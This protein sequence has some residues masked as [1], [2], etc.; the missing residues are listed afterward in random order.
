MLLPF[1][2]TFIYLMASLHSRLHSF[3]HHFRLS[4]YPMA[5]HVQPTSSLRHGPPTVQSWFARNC[6]WQ[7]LCSNLPMCKDIRRYK[8]CFFLWLFWHLFWTIQ[9]IQCPTVKHQ[10]SLRR[11]G[12]HECSCYSLRYNELWVLVM[13]V[14]LSHVPFGSWRCCKW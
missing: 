11:I 5:F 2:Q 7:D 9:T 3:W 4:T 6:L 8:L 1:D 12:W 14:W 10:S 13:Q